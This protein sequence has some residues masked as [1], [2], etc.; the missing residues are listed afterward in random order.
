MVGGYDM[1]LCI[2]ILKEEDLLDDLLHHFKENNVNN[3]TVLSST[4]MVSE[5]A[6]K[7]KNRDVHIFG[8]LHHL[9]DYFSDNSRVLM[10]V[11]EEDRVDIISKNIKKIIPEHEYL[12]FTVPINNIQGKLE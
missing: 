8:T 7:N 6:G 1:A 4:S 3:I 10:I 2:L 11:C 9:V 5:Y 12:F